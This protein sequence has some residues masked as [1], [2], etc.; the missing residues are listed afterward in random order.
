MS[1]RR[2]LPGVAV[3]LAVP[4]LFISMEFGVDETP[5]YNPDDSAV[6][7]EWMGLLIKLTEKTFGFTPPVAARAFGYEGISLYESMRFSDPTLKSLAG[8]I[9]G[10]DTNLL[11]GIDASGTYDWNIVANANLAAMARTMYPNALPIYKGKI[12]ALER[13]LDQRY[14]R[15][16]DPHTADNS[17]KL[18]RAIANAIA[19]Y[20]AS[21]GRANAYKM[22]FPK[23]YSPPTGNGM[24]VP[25]PRT[26][27][28]AMQ[29]TWG[30]VR[31]FLTKNVED[32][33]LPPPPT[34]S[35]DPSSPFFKDV[36]EVYDTVK[37]L[38]PEQLA[39]A[40]FWSDDPGKTGTPPGHSLSILKQVID[41]ENASL[42]TAAIAFA[43]MGIA[44]HDSFVACW[45]VKYTYNLIR[46]ITVIRNEIDREFD[47][48][49]D[50]PPFPEYPSGHSVQS[51]AA[52]KVLTDMFGENYHFTDM[53]NAGRTDMHDSTRT[54]D[55]FESFAQEA[56]MSRLYGGIHFRFSIERGL[57]QGRIIGNNVNQLS[58]K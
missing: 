43:R 36:Q 55:S 45:R 16:L 4:T 25:T 27:R 22:N 10:L 30:S 26:F 14:S 39:I 23:N 9:S 8:Q 2:Y 7:Q 24:W 42:N 48:P 33:M 15:V 47:I 20:A 51:A 57:E 53:T 3:L 17:R 58:F 19:Q 29:P 1:Y 52:A 50:T 40:E 35:L 21:D 5:P 6:V 46:P 12:D 38:T 49:L 32:T 34:Y 41:K 28:R 18:G 37:K 56:A 44:L 54:F 13:A 11:K 31:P